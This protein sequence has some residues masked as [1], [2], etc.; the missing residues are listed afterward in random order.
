MN[1]QVLR[2]IGCPRFETVS[3]RRGGWQHTDTGPICGFCVIRHELAASK[4]K[5]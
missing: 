3:S 5:Q 1:D 4:E 2:C